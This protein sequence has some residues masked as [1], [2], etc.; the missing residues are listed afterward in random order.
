M[1]VVAPPPPP[2]E[3]PAQL[4]TAAI[5]VVDGLVAS[6]KLPRAL[7]AALDAELAFARSS[8]TRGRPTIALA[9]VR[10]I[11]VELDSRRAYASCPATTRVHCAC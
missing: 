2:S 9:A 10:S 6:H 3:T 7:G 8:L 5:A 4:L 1:T 11:A